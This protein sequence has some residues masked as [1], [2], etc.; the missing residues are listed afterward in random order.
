MIRRSQQ[1]WS[2][3][4]ATT[5][6]TWQKLIQVMFHAELFFFSD[7]QGQDLAKLAPPAL[8]AGLDPLISFVLQERGLAIEVAKAVAQDFSELGKVRIVYHFLSLFFLIV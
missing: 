7:K 4:L 6:E 8:K 5:I 1:A 2:A 3:A